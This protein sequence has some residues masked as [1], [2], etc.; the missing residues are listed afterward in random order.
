MDNAENLHASEYKNILKTNGMKY[1]N[2]ELNIGLLKLEFMRVN[3]QSKA[4]DLAGLKY[5]H[6]ALELFRKMSPCRNHKV[7]CPTF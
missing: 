1:V 5:F 7:I 6:D 3:K 2:K 4:E